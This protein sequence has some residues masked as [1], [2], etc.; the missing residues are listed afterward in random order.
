MAAEEERAA[1]R[2]R[3]H[4]V[5]LIRARGSGQPVGPASHVM[6][7]A[8]PFRFELRSITSPNPLRADAPAFAEALAK[9][10]AGKML[11]NGLDVWCNR[12]VLCIEWDAD[13]LT[14]NSFHRGPWEE[15]LLALQ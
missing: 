5:P 15:E 3:D 14:V 11:P 1:A 6:W 7:A 8:G 4:I 2:I 10:D 12:K 9:H 13:K